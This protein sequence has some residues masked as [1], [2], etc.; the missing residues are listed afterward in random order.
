MRSRYT[1][2]VVKDI[3]HIARTNDPD[4]KDEFDR[5][6]AMEWAKN[7]EWLGLEVLASTEDTVEFIARFKANGKELAHHELSTFRKVNDDWY[8]VDGKTVQKPVVRTGPKVG[9][10]D[11]CPCGSGKK[12]KKCCA[13]SASTAD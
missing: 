6:M 2:Y 11:P 10:N 7:S 9:R 1:A 13:G 5:E 12:S 4:S 3:D 8:F